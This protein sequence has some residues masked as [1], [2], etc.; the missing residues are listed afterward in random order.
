MPRLSRRHFLKLTGA[1]PPSGPSHFHKG[2]WANIRRI[3]ENPAYL[4]DVSFKRRRY[5]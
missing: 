3:G 2:T 5:S 1:V 4:R